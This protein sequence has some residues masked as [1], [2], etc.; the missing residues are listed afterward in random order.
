MA[1]AGPEK[2]AKVDRPST[3]GDDGCKSGGLHVAT[4]AK[5]RIVV[6]DRVSKQLLILDRA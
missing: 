5:N 2:F 6:L 4:D 3:V 1:I